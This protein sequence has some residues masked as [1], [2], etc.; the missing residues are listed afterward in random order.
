[1]YRILDDENWIVTLIDFQNEIEWRR[2]SIRSCSERMRF[3]VLRASI[4]RRSNYMFSLLLHV[5]WTHL[6]NIRC[7]NTT[8]LWNVKSRIMFIHTFH[9][10]NYRINIHIF[11]Y[12]SYLSEKSYQWKISYNIL[13]RKALIFSA[14]TVHSNTIYNSKI[15]VPQ[16]TFWEV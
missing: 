11:S 12:A 1:M 3:D 16:R 14:H 13:M 10:S 7:F 4:L 6:S 8:I 15:F 5:K 2:N 9:I